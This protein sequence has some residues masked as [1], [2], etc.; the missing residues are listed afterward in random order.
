MLDVDSFRPGGNLEIQKYLL[1]IL[2]LLQLLW[3][4][5]IPAPVEHVTTVSRTQRLPS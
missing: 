1:K 3:P 4:S 5:G 2:K